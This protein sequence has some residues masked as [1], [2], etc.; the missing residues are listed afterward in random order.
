MAQ[1]PFSTFVDMILDVANEPGDHWHPSGFSPVFDADMNF[2]GFTQI[3]VMTEILR[4]AR[5][6]PGDG[7]EFTGEA[8][9]IRRQVDG[10]AAH[11]AYQVRE[12]DPTDMPGL[13]VP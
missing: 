8:F 11:W 10:V 1:P 9:R 4:L 6:L 2:V 12:G 7:F 3:K 13:W 5:N